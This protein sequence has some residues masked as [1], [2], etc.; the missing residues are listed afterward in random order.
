MS[1]IARQTENVIIENRLAQLKITHQQKVNQSKTTYNNQRISKSK[2]I[3]RGSWKTVS[4]M[5]NDMNNE[6]PQA[7][8][9][10]SGEKISGA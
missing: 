4:E 2:N 6:Y 8:I 10:E 3:T 9:L 7:I 1:K 5:R